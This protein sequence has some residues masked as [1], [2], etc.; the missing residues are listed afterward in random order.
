MIERFLFEFCLGFDHGGCLTVSSLWRVIAAG[1]AMSAN[2]TSPEA[3]VRRSM[4]MTVHEIDEL[5]EQV[6]KCAAVVD[7]ATH[8]FL[9]QV[10]AFDEAGGWQQQ[11]ATSMAAWL[12]YRVG[13][14]PGVAREKVRVSRVLAQLPATDDA[15][16]LGQI[17]YWKVR[18][19]S[20]VATADS[21][22]ELL[23]LAAQTTGA[24][25]EKVCRLFRQTQREGV[26][27]ECEPQRWVH[28]RGTQDSMVRLTVQVRP[29]EAATL[30]AAMESASD[31][32]ELVDGLMAMAE[33][34]ARGDKPHRPP[35]EV[36]VHVNAD[37]LTGE[38]PD[39][40]GVPTEVCERLLCDA[41]VIPVLEDKHGQTLNVGRKSRSVPAAVRRAL[42]MRDKGCRVPGCDHTRWV[43]AHHIQ[44]WARGG[45]TSLSNM[46]LLCSA[47]HRLLHDGVI[48]IK[49]SEG[50]ELL[51][52]DQWG[53]EL[54]R[55]GQTPDSEGTLASLRTV[56]RPITSDCNVPLWD[57]WPVDYSAVVDGLHAM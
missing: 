18:E 19:L 31:T 14:T 15:L 24:Q 20:R 34:T 44:H 9:T 41:G 7:A 26:P 17:S 39:G 2:V 47:H 16:R 46:V 49:V 36:V 29:E 56:E 11:G 51:F 55:D 50:G 10:R 33:E 3:V 42:R 32:G 1:L 4:G 27:A 40:S 12:A 21:E 6:A 28:Q 57:G 8:E 37:T 45:D 43:D 5:G 52:H 53:R 38:L 54:A 35:A 25:F 22:A 48:G 30:T 13:L 23:E